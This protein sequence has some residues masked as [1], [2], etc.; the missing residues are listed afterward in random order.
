MATGE[1]TACRIESITATGSGLARVNDRCIFTDLAAPGDLAK[2]RI[3][4]EQRGWSRA[5]ILEILEFSPLRTAPIC[6]LYGKCGGCNLAHIN[7]A[8]QLEIK[9]KIIRES[10]LR[11]G[12]YSLPEVHLFASPPQ[13]YRNRVQFHCPVQNRKNIGF[14]ERK[15]SEIIPLTDCPVAD[16]GIRRALGDPGKKTLNPPVHKDRFTVYSRG[17]V[18]LSEGSGSRGRITLGKTNQKEIL[19]DAEVFFQ[20]N[21]GMLELLLEDLVSLAKTC[22]CTLPLADI[23][24]G[25]GTFTLFLGEYFAETELIEE[26]KT[27]I[28]LARENTNAKNHSYYCLKADD[29]VKQKKYAEKPWGLIVT[30][31][32]RTGLSI[33]LKEFL[34]VAGTNT[35]AYVSCDPVT[36]ARDSKFLMNAGFSLEKLNLYDF[37]P[38]TAHI[39]SLAIF[40]KES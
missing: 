8:A 34:A 18:F 7:Y 27:A 23:Y 24:C 38:Q 16:P 40:K 36:L 12:G 30:D 37:Y 35:L 1:I 13:E 28:A 26:N 32:P 5:E 29:W 4:E 19:I 11:T 17:G 10:F 9:E 33:G 39:E 22:D 6:P 14:K 15:G 2:V 20:S 21:C 25:V 31:P 3:T